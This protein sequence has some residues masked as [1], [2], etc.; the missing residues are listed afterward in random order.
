[1]REKL[2]QAVQWLRSLNRRAVLIGCLIVVSTGHVGRLF[3]DRED[4]RQA[5]LGYVLAV[6][7]D[8][9]LVI[10]LYDV[11]NVRK[12]LPRM[13]ALFVFLAACSISAG[14]NVRY[15]QL[16]YPDDPLEISVLLGVTA[17]VL[18]ALVTLLM[19]FSDVQR[20]KDELEEATADR[21]LELA[22]YQIEQ[23]EETK[24]VQ[25]AEQE[26][27]KRERARARAEQA[28]ANA[29]IQAESTASVQ[30]AEHGSERLKPGELDNKVRAILLDEPDIG[31]RPLARKLGISPSTA[32]GILRR[33]KD[34]GY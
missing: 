20:V 30:V 28:R 24:R 23:A 1:M 34:N 27:T 19:A 21:E 15:Y 12:W 29:L 26:R 9:V 16:N 18:A 17:P 8:A 2:R 4:V 3:A 6:C 22:K 31:P 5:F 13:F 25:L 32:S 14:F 11:V 7:V 33:V 10:A